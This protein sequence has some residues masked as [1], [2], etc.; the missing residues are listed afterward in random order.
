MNRESPTPIEVARQSLGSSDRAIYQR[1]ARTARSLAPKPAGR[2]PRL[3]DVGCGQGLLWPF[4]RPF[5]DRY[6]GVDLVRYETF[7]D[8]AEFLAADLNAQ[9]IP[10]P[11]ESADLVV[12]C[13]TIEHLEN[14]RQFARELTRLAAPN[15]IMIVTTPNQLSW[16]SKGTLLSRNQFNAFQGGSYPAHI[17]ALLEVDLLR[18][19]RECGWMEIAVHYTD[20]GR[21][22]GTPWHWPSTWPFRGRRFSDNVVLV[23]R[24]RPSSSGF[25]SGPP[26]ATIDP[27]GP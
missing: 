12:A 17:T 23:G 27:P 7:P 15:G 20:L 24:K 11:S 26:T 2:F 9:T 1:V 21:V 19:A 22:P 4:L 6:L 5:C 10:L 18:I 8:D 13:E 25:P 3:I 16:L 14:P